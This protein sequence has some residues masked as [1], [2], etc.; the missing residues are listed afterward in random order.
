[1]KRKITNWGL[2]PIQESEVFDFSE[3]N[4]LASIIKGNNE[5]I[6]RGMGRCYGDASLSPTTLSTLKYNKFLDFDIEK[7]IIEC[8]A[9]CYV[10]GGSGCLCTKRMVET[11][12]SL[13]KTR[14]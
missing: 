12:I 3:L 7:G 6:A 4:N 13:S 2:Y 10:G 8:Q 9:G 14:L 11:D 5:L 1:M